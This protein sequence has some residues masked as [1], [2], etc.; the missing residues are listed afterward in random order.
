ML[1][2]EFFIIKISMD[3]YGK[4]GSIFFLISA[5]FIRRHEIINKK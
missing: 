1:V 3:I 2:K 4:N 5:Y